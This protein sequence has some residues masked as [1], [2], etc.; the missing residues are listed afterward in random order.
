M[1]LDRTPRYVIILNMFVKMFS[2]IL[3]S[4]IS[5]DVKLRR[6]FMDL[7]L[8]C[9]FEGFIMITKDGIARRLGVDEAEVEWGL[10]ELM[11]P[12]P[13]SK[14][15]EYGG[16][17]V[18][19]IDGMAYGWQV[20]TFSKYRT[21]KTAESIRDANRKRQE[22]YRKRLADRHAARKAKAHGDDPHGDKDIEDSVDVM[23]Y[24]GPR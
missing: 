12:D 2:S 1:A 5:R 13:Q 9:D 4:S 20:V 7:L 23:D 14:N 10:T 11:K 16:A 6:F 15:K 3:D 17:R 8:L 18:I 24:Q 22:A 21:L 19:P